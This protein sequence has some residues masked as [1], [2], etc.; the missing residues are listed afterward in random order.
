MSGFVFRTFLT[1]SDLQWRSELGLRSF[2]IKEPAPARVA[3]DYFHDMN[4]VRSPSLQHF[5]FTLSYGLYYL[6]IATIHT[7]LA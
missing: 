5:T 6:I 7:D 4:V 3:L 1:R 2:D